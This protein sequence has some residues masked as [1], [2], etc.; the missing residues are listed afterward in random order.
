MSASQQQFQIKGLI[1]LG[2]EKGFLTL[3]EVS[4][5]LTDVVDAEQIDDV[6]SMI[7]SLDIEVHDEAPDGESRFFSEPAALAADDDDAAEEAAATLAAANSELGRTTDP[8]RMYMREMGGIGLL[9]REGEVRIA[10]RIEEGLGEALHALA[11]YPATGTLLLEAYEAAVG[12]RRRLAEVVLGFFDPNAEPPPT[13]VL[14]P[15]TDI[16]AADEIEEVVE[17]EGDEEEAVASGPDPE[18][19]A[20]A[21]AQL[22]SLHSQA[23]ALLMQAGGSGES[24]KRFNEVADL[25]VTFRLAPKFA[26]EIALSLRNRIEAI[27]SLEL[28]ILDVAVND[29]GMSREEFLTKLNDEGST[30]LAWVDKAIRAKR[31][32]S[33]TLACRKADIEQ[34]VARL[35]EIEEQDRLSINEI[36]DI[37]RRMTVG[38]SKA[39]RAKK[40]LVEANLRLVISIAKKYN[41]RGLQF[42]D[43]IQEGNLGL[44]KAVDKFEY[45]RGFKF[46]TYATWWIRQA[47]SRA[48]AD[49]ARTIR[50]PVHMVE[51]GNK[52]ARTSRQMLQE[53]GRE[54]TLSELAAKLELSEDKVHKALSIVREPIS[55]D[56]PIGEDGDSF[57]G[58]FIADAGAASPLDH[59][60]SQSLA[61]MTREILDGLTPREAKVL[62]MRFGIETDS[63][64]TLEEVGL[65][66]GVTRER[67]RQIEAKV[68]RKLRHPSCA[69]YLRSFVA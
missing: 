11:T 25:V 39:R 45:R 50:I 1:A 57:L 48:I 9:D 38:E 29:A 2:K 42:L 41:N 58:D 21:F 52:V 36:K 19:A 43:L 14:S 3:A 23:I 37:Y 31:K 67:I 63:E 53:M 20:A 44:M 64:H 5:H 15:E 61:E 26:A 59:A 18:Q 51:S 16:D 17:G 22:R 68:L 54:P 66:F 65:Q 46:S 4:D 33:A 56:A 49:Q 8:V 69:N 32:Y 47:I 27:R 28:A 30:S 12:G 62:R 55:M 10:K 60:I 35:R 24:R 6:I 40:E 34:L 7:R 13:E